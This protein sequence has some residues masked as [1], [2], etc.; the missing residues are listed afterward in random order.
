MSTINPILSDLGSNRDL[1]GGKPA[2]KRLRY[3]KTNK[4]LSL[5]IIITEKV[6]VEQNF[7]VMNFW[8]TLI[9][10]SIVETDSQ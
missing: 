8:N 7:T 1:L 6:N 9:V 4:L 2:I 10:P 5:E 3:G